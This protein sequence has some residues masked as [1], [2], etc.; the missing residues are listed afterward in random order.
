MSKYDKEIKGNDPELLN[1]DDN[2]EY[3]LSN[4]IG[5][6]SDDDSN[7]S[8]EETEEEVEEETEEEVEEEPKEKTYTK[9]QVQKIVQTRVKNLKSKIEKDKKYKEALSDISDIT[10]LPEDKI[11]TQLKNMTVKEKAKVLGLTETQVLEAEKNKKPR[12]S[13][14]EIEME[15]KLGILELKS[16]VKDIDIFED[17][18]KELMQDNSKLTVKQ[19]YLLAKDASGGFDFDEDEEELDK[20]LKA[21]EKKAQE[22]LKAKQLKRKQKAG[23]SS[24]GAS[25]TGSKKLDKRIISAAKAVGM[26]PK[27]YAQYSQMKNLDDYKKYQNERKK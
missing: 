2:E 18:I 4:L 27:E 5:E 10:G 12:K 16:S 11:L 25:K 9:S 8:V 21:A 23:A 14:K 1:S 3:S 19:A 13:T 26:D 6:E 15:T 17:E 22:T 20:K 7:E 24:L